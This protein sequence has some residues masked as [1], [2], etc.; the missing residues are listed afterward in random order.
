MFVLEKELW[1]LIEESVERANNKVDV[2]GGRAS[3]KGREI[4][5]ML[6]L[7]DGVNF[8][9]W[10]RAVEQDALSHVS[11]PMAAFQVETRRWSNT[12]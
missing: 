1:K 11:L 9:D 6:N 5:L 3:R 4:R 7:G 8:T 10:R 12:T 2:Q